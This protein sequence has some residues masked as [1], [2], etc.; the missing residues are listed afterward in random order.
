MR[1]KKRNRESGA[2]VR[3]RYVERVRE[4]ER[5]RKIYR[6]SESESGD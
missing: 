4:R 2:E 3:R 6:E 5:K 1:E